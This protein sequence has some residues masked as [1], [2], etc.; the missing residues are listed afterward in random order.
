MSRDLSVVYGKYIK[1]CHS[2]IVTIRIIDIVITETVPNCN[3]RIILTVG[4]AATTWLDRL[5][6]SSGF[7][8]V[9]NLQIFRLNVLEVLLK[10]TIEKLKV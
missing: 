9:E 3:T 1:Q 2:T 7:N 4:N 6:F 5:H 8:G 10:V